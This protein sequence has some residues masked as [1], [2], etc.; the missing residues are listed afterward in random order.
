MSPLEGLG[1]H[2]YP[3]QRPLRLLKSSLVTRRRGWMRRPRTRW[4]DYVSQLACERLGM[5][6]SCRIFVLLTD[7]TSQE[8]FSARIED[9]VDV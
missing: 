8:D 3:W 6:G 2:Q 1:E 5:D 7:P 4:R 9:N